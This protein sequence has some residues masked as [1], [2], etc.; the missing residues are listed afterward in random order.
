MRDLVVAYRLVPAERMEDYDHSWLKLQDLAT[1]AGLRAW[2]FRSVDVGDEFVEFLEGS[3]ASDK[4]TVHQLESLR[5]KLDAV[6]PAASDRHWEEA[7]VPDPSWPD[8]RATLLSLLRSRSLKRGQFVL[9]SG[10]RSDYYIDARP[11]TMSASGQK[12]IGR[13]GLSRI[14]EQGWSVSA[15]GGLTLGADPVAYAIAHASA[16]QGRSIDAFTVRKQVKEHG[17]ARRIE[18]NLTAGGDVVIVEDVMTSGGSALDAAVAAEEAGARVLGVLAVVDRESGGREKLA[19]AGYALFS[20]FSA[21][22]LLEG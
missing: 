8:E 4:G 10:K 21:W 9:A 1:R 16:L 12:L 14:E 13:L 2:R 19:Q 5:Q 3:G 11:T 20:L 6:A 15:V 22:E 18:G 7:P 17:T